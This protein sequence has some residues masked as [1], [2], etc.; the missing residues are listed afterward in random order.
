MISPREIV[1]LLDLTMFNPSRSWDSINEY[2]GVM[3]N[4]GP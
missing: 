3:R 2:Q 1:I 4:N